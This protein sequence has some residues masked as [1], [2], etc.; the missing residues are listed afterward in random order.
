[1]P[2][3]SF[4]RVEITSAPYIRCTVTIDGREFDARVPWSGTGLIVL[5]GW[6][7][8]DNDGIREALLSFIGKSLKGVAR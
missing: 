3:I 1:M 7:R 2:R 4:D 8:A 5:D 6:Q